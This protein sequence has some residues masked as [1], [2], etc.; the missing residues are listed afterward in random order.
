[1]QKKRLFVILGSLFVAGVAIAGVLYVTFPVPMTTYGGMGLNF[2]KS[3]SAP[4]GTLT[5]ETNPAYQAPAAAAPAPPCRFAVAQCG[6]R[7]LAELQQD[8]DLAALLAA[9]ADQREECRQPEDPVHVRPRR[10]HGLRVRPDHGEQRADRHRRV[11][12]LLHQPGHVRRELAYAPQLSRLAAAGQSRCRLHGRPAVSRHAGLPRAGLRFQ[13]RQAGV[14]DDDLPTRSAASRCRRR[15]SRWMVS[16]TSAMPAA[17]TRAARA[18]STRSTER[19]AR[20]SGSS[21]SRPR[22]KAMSS[23]AR[24]ASR[25]STVRPGTTRRAYR[26][27]A[28]D[29]GPR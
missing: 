19:P 15:R 27:A 17:T 16:S 14:G 9:G 11:R 18:R 24:W 28:P 12:D 13:D 10:V 5:V 8:A 26:S 6:G 20:S 3:L 21:S 23:G 4:A 22:S 2:L 29:S 7:R 1:M 25:R